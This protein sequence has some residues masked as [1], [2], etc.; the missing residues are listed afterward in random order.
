MQQKKMRDIIYELA[1][2]NHQIIATTHSPYMIDLSK[3]N[4]QVLNSFKMIDHDYACVTP[5]NL[6]QAFTKLIDDD[7]TRVKLLQKIDSYVARIFFTQKTVIVEGDTEDIVF[8]QTI[9]VMPIEIKK[10]IKDK[11][12]IIKATGKATMISFIK[13]LQALSVDVFVV[14]DE[15]AKTPGAEKM[16]GPILQALGGNE[17]KRLMMHNCIEDELGYKAPSS[18]KPYH[19]F[20]VVKDWNNWHCVPENWKQIVR[21]VFSEFSEDL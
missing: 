9:N 8:R 4:R 18:D 20:L 12:Q 6:T 5:F 3:D 1:T 15:D 2:N 7:K 14:H 10:A 19:A 11:Y 16:N 17:T 21:K 13:Y